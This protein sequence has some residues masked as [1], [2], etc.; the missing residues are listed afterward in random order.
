M[1]LLYQNYTPSHNVRIVNHK[2][3]GKTVKFK[4]VA[5]NGNSYSRLN[6]Y[7]INPQTGLH[8]IADK[9][10][11][12]GY[13]VVSYECHDSIRMSRSQENLDKAEDWIRT[14]FM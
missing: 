7:I 2:Y 4:I 10:D 3:D 14:V 1:E 11:I 8:L 9:D 12:R 5:E 13:N 6:I